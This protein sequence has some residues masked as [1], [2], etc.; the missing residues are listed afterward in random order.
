MT[1]TLDAR[2][3]RAWFRSIRRGTKESDAVIGGFVERQLDK[4]DEG[5]LARLEALLDCNDQD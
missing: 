1:D 2:R 5:Q 3:K 4:L